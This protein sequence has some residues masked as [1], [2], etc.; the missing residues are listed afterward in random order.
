MKYATTVTLIVDAKNNDEAVILV[1]DILEKG[2]IKTAFDRD[3][4]VSWDFTKVGDQ[5]LYPTRYYEGG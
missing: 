1:T 2:K 5:Y 3:R 4:L